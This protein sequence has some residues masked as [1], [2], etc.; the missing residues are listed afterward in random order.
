VP[1]SVERSTYVLLASLVLIL[2]FWRCHPMPDVLW[3]VDNE[4]GRTALWALFV[5]GWLM[6]LTSTFLI[7]HFD[8]FGLRQ[9]LLNLRGQ[10]YTELPFRVV[11]FY[12]LVRHPPY[13][14][15]R[16]G[17]LRQ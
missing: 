14:G 5:L 11:F 10:P 3:N 16:S 2:L 4:L 7:N 8:L 1:K 12:L 13:L 9:L 17:P 6:V 15:S